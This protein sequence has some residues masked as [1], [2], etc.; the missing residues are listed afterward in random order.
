MNN[1]SVFFLKHTDK[2]GNIKNG[3]NAAQSIQQYFGEF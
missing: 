1:C 3:N 2:Q